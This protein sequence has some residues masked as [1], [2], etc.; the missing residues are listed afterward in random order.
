MES[1]VISSHQCTP[2]N[3]FDCFQRLIMQNV[4]NNRRPPYRDPARL[5]SPHPAQNQPSRSSIFLSAP[6]ARM[7]FP[8]SVG[9][10]APRGI[11]ALPGRGTRSVPRRLPHLHAVSAQADATDATGIHEKVRGRSRRLR[12][13]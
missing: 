8:F 10:A 7:S 9:Y 13:I 2:Y 6:N 12:I 11:A 5:A 4:S 3:D 1:R